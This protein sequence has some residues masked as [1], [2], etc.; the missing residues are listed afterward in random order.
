M[1]E[2]ARMAGARRLALCCAAAASI[3]VTA[4]ALATL[5]TAAREAARDI[6]FDR[7]KGNCLAC[8]HLPT[9]VGAEQP[10]NS[11]PPLIAMQA[12]FPDKRVLRAKIWDATASTPDSFMPPFGRHQILTEDE[13]DLV[14]EF[15]YGL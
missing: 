8:H 1:A 14:V 7:A 2:R 5:N 15:I 10:G 13:I 9:L 4:P 3:G 6:L 12:R 11:G